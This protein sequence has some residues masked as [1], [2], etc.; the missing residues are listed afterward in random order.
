MKGV[1]QKNKKTYQNQT[2]QQKSHPRNKYMGNPPSKIFLR[3]TKEELRLMDQMTRK[4]IIM[5][6]DFYQ[7]DD[8]DRFYA[9]RK[10]SRRGLA[11]TEDCIKVTI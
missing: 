10:E 11:N 9:A 7:R 2:L 3:W 8:M 5:H 6:K 4:L 1:P